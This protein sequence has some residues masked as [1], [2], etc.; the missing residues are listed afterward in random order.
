GE[1]HVIHRDLVSVPLAEALCCDHVFDVTGADAAPASDCRMNLARG[2]MA[3][4]C[5]T[6]RVGRPDPRHI[7]AD[8]RDLAEIQHPDAE[9]RGSAELCRVRSGPSGFVMLARRREACGAVVQWQNFC[10]P[11]R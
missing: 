10:F 4:W 6:P 8:L 1:R 9:L 2:P 5:H 11:S 7:S 3:L